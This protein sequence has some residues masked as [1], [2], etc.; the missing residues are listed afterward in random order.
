[1]RVPKAGTRASGISLVEVVVAL[2][3]LVFGALAAVSVMLSSIRLDQANRE[4]AL[5]RQA[6][7]QIVETMKGTTFSK[8]FA[9]YDADPADDPGGAGT[10]PGATFAVK[11]LDPQLGAASVGTIVFPT[12]GGALREDA[13]LTD[14]GMPRDLNGDGVVDSAN[15]A[16][17]YFVLP[18]KILVQWRGVDGD[19][20]YVLRTVICP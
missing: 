11:G 18:V 12:V 15:H 9:T 13:A 19:R 16:G 4:D 5:A 6:A 17:D 7:R 10:A 2:T 14:L 20:S 8:I 1:M 3:V